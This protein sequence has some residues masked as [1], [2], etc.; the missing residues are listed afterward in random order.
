MLCFTRINP[1]NFQTHTKAILSSIAA[2]LKV[3]SQLFGT[4]SVSV[5]G[6]SVTLSKNKGLVVP[7]DFHCHPSDRCTGAVSP[8]PAPICR[9][10]PGQPD[11]S[12]NVWSIKHTFLI[13]P[14]CLYRDQGLRPQAL[15]SICHIR[16]PSFSCLRHYQSLGLIS[17]LLITTPFKVAVC[18]H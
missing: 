18:F 12:I 1:V 7:Q 11:T 16:N 10:R 5:G 15:Y 13:D 8:T 9:H 17:L 6:Q 4:A 14:L 3:F 2:F